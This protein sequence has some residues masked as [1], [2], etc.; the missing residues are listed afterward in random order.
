MVELVAAAH[1]AVDA[2]QRRA[3]QRQIA[4]GVERLVAGELVGEAQAFGIEQPLF[5]D[6]ERVLER[7]AERVTAR[8][9]ASPR[10]S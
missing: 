6:D 4:D 3:G 7:G 10:P 8:S 1:R 9:K 2:E 5:V